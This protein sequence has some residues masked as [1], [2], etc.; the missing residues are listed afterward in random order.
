[1]DSTVIDSDVATV[2]VRVMADT[3]KVSDVIIEDKA[4]IALMEKKQKEFSKANAERA[5]KERE[6][7]KKKAAADAVSF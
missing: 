1:M 6:A 3:G 4:V 7:A 2:S 5:K